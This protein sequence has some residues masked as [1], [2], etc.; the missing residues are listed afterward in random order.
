MNISQD[1]SLSFILLCAV[2]FFREKRTL[3][4]DLSA[5]KYCPHFMIKGKDQYLGIRLTGE[6]KPEFTTWLECRAEPLYADMDYSDLVGGAE[7]F[8]IEGNN[9]VGEG[10]VNEILR[11]DNMN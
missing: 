6:E 3:P 7:F 4:P 1:R 2:R 10:I 9:K 5:G 8:I 11:T